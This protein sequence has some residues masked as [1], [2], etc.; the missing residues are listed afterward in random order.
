MAIFCQVDRGKLNL[1]G[2]SI[3]KRF[4]SIIFRLVMFLYCL[5]KVTEVLKT[6]RVGM[7]VSENVTM[8]A[9]FLTMGENISVNVR[10]CNLKN[11]T[12]KYFYNSELTW[13]SLQKSRILNNILFSV[14]LSRIDLES[15]SYGEAEIPCVCYYR[16]FSQNSKY[17]NYLYKWHIMKIRN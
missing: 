4:L 2:V 11:Q 3:V 15:I 6:Q 13:Y 5:L 9:S 7:W 1:F 10:T 17:S 16:Q 14:L 12:K 8:W